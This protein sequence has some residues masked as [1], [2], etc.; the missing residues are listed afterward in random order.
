MTVE[1]VNGRLRELSQIE[2]VKVGAYERKRPDRATV[3][4][5]GRALRANEPWAGY[6]ELTVAE[7]RAVLAR[8]RRGPH[9]GGPRVRAGPQ[10]PRRRP[11]ATDR[12]QQKDKNGVLLPR[13]ID[14]DWVLLHRPAAV[15]E[16]MSGCRARRQTSRRWRGPSW[17]WAGARAM[18]GLGAH[19]DR[20]TAARKRA[21]LAGR[22]SRRAPDRRRRPVPRGPGAAR[23]RAA[24]NRPAA[25]GRVV[26]GPG[27]DYEV[28]GDVP[29]VVP[30]RTRV[31]A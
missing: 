3:P 21:R 27:A 30:V 19:R 22:L 12:D 8:G 14:G 31:L 4:R 23:P 29:N 25:L 18:V 7:V 1:E 16:P 11:R 6:D 5:Q 28:S 13:R 2:L 15:T 9:E 26:L 10:E 17:S 20:T 24:G